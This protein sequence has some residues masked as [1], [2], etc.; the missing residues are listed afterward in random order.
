MYCI[1]LVFLFNKGAV[2]FQ[3]KHLGETRV[4]KGFQPWCAV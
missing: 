2:A 3:G 4:R 1:I